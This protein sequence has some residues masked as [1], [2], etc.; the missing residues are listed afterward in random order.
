[1]NLVSGKRYVI[2]F[3]DL[4]FIGLYVNSDTVHH[5]KEV[6]GLSD[7]PEEATFSNKCTF[8]GPIEPYVDMHTILDSIL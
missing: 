8:I 5:F 6:Y 1:M 7:T 2:T 4:L 3:E